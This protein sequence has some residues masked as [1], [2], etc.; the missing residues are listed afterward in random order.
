MQ[1]RQLLQKRAGNSMIEVVAASVILATALV[2]ALRMM[3]D[4]LTVGREVELADAMATFCASKLEE[5]LNNVCG[6]WNMSTLTGS[7][8]AQGYT[9]LKYI[10]TKSDSMSDGGL[11]NRLMA[12]TAEVWDDVNNNNAIDGDEHRVRFST[13]LAKSVSY[14]Y[15]ASGN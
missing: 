10:V 13:K 4:S 14:N 15:E 11:P 12:I 2:P 8:A 1:T 3:R 7:Y 5:T 9:Q 6:S